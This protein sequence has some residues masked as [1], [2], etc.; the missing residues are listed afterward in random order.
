MSLVL[1]RRQLLHALTLSGLLGT[2]TPPHLPPTSYRK[3]PTMH[4]FTRLAAT[5]SIAA[6]D[7]TTG[8]VGVAVQTHQMGVGRLV[9]W[10]RPG[11]GAV[12]TQSLVNVSYGPNG[13][14]LLAAGTTPDEVIA[15]LTADDPA[16]FHRQVGVVS[17]DGQ[18]AAFTGEHCIRHAGHHVGAGYSV[19]ANM[20]TNPT[21][22]EAMRLTYET[23]TGDLAARLLAALVAAQDEGGDIR[24]MQSAALLIVPPATDTTPDHA[25]LYDLR[26]DEHPAPVQELLRL[27]RLRRAQLVSA[28]G[29]VAFGAGERDEALRLWAAAR[30][31]AP[32]LEELA[33]WQAIA[34]ADGGNDVATA[35]A[36]FQPVFRE[37]PLR[38]QWIDLIGRLEEAKLIAR[39]G[40]ALELVTA[41]RTS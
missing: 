9:P 34:L 29:D 36:I 20:M 35:A 37:D 12:A 41:L 22:I 32:E 14:A 8:E 16:A 7:P 11:V 38:E 10:A 24:G 19:H 31:Q 25:T 26:V 28:A 23:H 5:Y 30:A 21:V 3:Q 13:L 33:F 17:A 15:R 18:A 39:E 27:A 6:H 2:F 4:D 1:T 40:A